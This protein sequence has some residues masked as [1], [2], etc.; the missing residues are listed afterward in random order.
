MT[1][2]ST[3][4]DSLWQNLI[5]VYFEN[6]MEFFFPQVHKLI[7]W[8]RSHQFL[9]KELQNL[10][11]DASIKRICAENLV[12]VRLLNRKNAGFC[13]YINVQLQKYDLFTQR[14]FINN[15]R[16]FDRYGTQVMS[17]AILGDS[18]PDWRPKSYSH[19][20]IGFD[21]SCN[22]PIMKLTDYREKGGGLEKS[23]NLFAMVVRIHLVKLET[24]KNSTKR[25]DEKLALFKA[26]HEAHYSN[27]VFSDLFRFLDGVL[28]VPS[29]LEQQFNDFVKQYNLKNKSEVV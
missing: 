10:V 12:K 25:F 17:L 19:N 11:K 13:I 20:L 29:L 15:S 1:Q 24:S 22:F 5:E 6:F 28:V 16:L 14:M 8:N 4:L 18:E 7:D 21:L 2:V 9:N 27:Q 23:N 3:K 26:L